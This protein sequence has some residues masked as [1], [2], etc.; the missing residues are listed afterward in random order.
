MSTILDKLQHLSLVQKICS[1][2]DNHVGINDST[3]AEFIIELHSKHET[4][5]TFQRELAENGAEFEDSFVQSLH[6]LIATMKPKPKSDS[7]SASNNVRSTAK[8]GSNPSKFPGLSMPN[9]EPI[10]LLDD[11]QSAPTKTEPQSQSDEPSDELQ[12]ERMKAELAMK[13]LTQSRKRSRIKTEDSESVRRNEDSNDDRY[14]RRRDD[15]RDSRDRKP[16]RDDS[17]RRRRDDDRDGN[18][19]SGPRSRSS[20]RR[21][22]DDEYRSRDDDYRRRDDEYRR[23]DEDRRSPDDSRRRGRDDRG[24]RRDDRRDDRDGRRWD[25]RDDRR[26][27]KPERREVTLNSIFDGSVSNVRDFGCFV[28]LE[29]VVGNNVEG[30]VHVS[31]IRTGGRVDISQEVKRGQKVKVKVISMVKN[32]IGL[33]MRAVDQKTGE[34]LYPASNV[35][36]QVSNLSHNPSKPNETSTNILD[37]KRS[38][39][40]SEDE[41]SETRRAKRLSSPERWE[42]QQLINSGVLP[43][44]EYPTFDDET[45]ILNVEETEEELDIEINDEEPAFLLGQTSQT[46]TLSPIKVLK[47]PDGTLQRAAFLQTA[48]AKERRD[49]RDQQSKQMADSIPMDLGRS[50]EDPMAPKSERYLAQ[51]LHG[52]GNKQP[53]LPAWKKQNVGRNVSYGRVTTLSIKEQRESLPIYKLRNQLMKA[54]SENDILIVIGE[55]GSGKTTQMTQYLA[56]YGYASKG[57]IGCTQPRRV[58]AMSV[59]KRVSEE[60]GCR[61]GQE[62]GYSI[63]FEDMTSPETVIKYMTDGML[64]REALLDQDLSVYSV[65]LLDEAHE[66]T[67]HTDV[68]FG[69]L[70]AC[71]KRRKGMKLI[72]TSA[73]LKAEKF[74]DYFHHCPIFTIP[75]RLFP[76]Q[77]MYAKTPEPDYLDAALITVMQIHLAEPPGDILLFLTGKEEIDTACE[78]LFDRMKS[79]GRG[80]PPLAVLPVYSALPSEMQT[81]I[82][83]PAPDGHRKCVVATN[84]AEASLTIDGIYYV[85]DPGFVK[86]KL[87]NAKLG[88]DSLVVTPISQ[89]S[90]NQRAGRA[91]RTGPGKCFRLYTKAAYKTEM[92]E[93]SVPEIQRTNLGN[94]VLTLKAMGINDLIGFGFMDPP[95]F[96]TLVSALESLYALGALDDEGLLTRLGRKMAEFPLEPQQSKVLIQSV[97]F[98]CS[99]EVLT[100]VAMLSADNIWYRPRDKQALADQKRAKFFQPEGDLLTILAVYQAWAKHKFSNTWCYENFIQARAM[101]R[102][103]DVRKQLV[104]IMDRYKLNIV[105]CGRHF[106]RVRRAITSGYFTHSAKKD[107]QEG[108]KTLLEGQPVFIHPSSS[109]FNHQPAWIVYHHLVLTTKEYMRDVIAIEPKW[110]VELA[111]R[112]FKSADP[113]KLS[114]RKRKEKIEP[115]YDRYAVPNAWRLSRRL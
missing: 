29:N 92:M 32:K 70:K 24:G 99:E 50:W 36:G 54:I 8:I 58:A 27:V 91:G 38:V 11:S 3:L 73:T 102:A 93:A 115:L 114:R 14:K 56:E 9:S 103:Q 53:E 22:R 101:R 49:L 4:P 30:L 63:R 83:E 61:L 39:L 90:A 47:N 17:R 84:I 25:K 5:Q 111:P 98:G 10:N 89:N 65:I 1:E 13:E 69:L 105:S 107:P 55:T 81:R 78:I 76:V 96:Q 104:T 74:S 35:R 2:L 42:L 87:Y 62:V 18:D 16:E 79:L 106:D 80:A 75:G 82:F 110:L 108:Y 85:V 51:E 15:N 45:G 52:M 94:T 68:L 41:Q 26:F 57:R 31:M 59:A 43:V 28:R 71:V 46:L 113:T 23:R 21:D 77:V 19:E 86:Q 6:R 20:R 72:V 97:D 12:K 66:R 64:L 109:L 7:V 48:L 33:S 44:T 60:F 40:A 112:I 67:I 88:M 100:I 37:R 34:D 95:P